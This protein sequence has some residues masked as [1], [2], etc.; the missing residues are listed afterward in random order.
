[1]NWKKWIPK[2]MLGR[3]D[4]GPE[5]HVTAYGF[6]WKAVGSVLVLRFAPGSRDAYHSHAFDAVSWVL[7]PGWL[8]E[9]ATGFGEHWYARDG[10]PIHTPRERHHRV[11]SRGVTWVLSLRGP[12]C[13]TW[14]DHPIGAEPRTLTHGRVEVRP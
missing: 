13:D 2:L 7:G 5:S 11:E 6:E 10:Y 1:M 14:V 9:H 4:G 12:W 8:H 3:K